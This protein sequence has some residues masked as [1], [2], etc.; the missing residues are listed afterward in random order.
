MTADD[1][2]I[3]PVRLE[4]AQALWRKSSGMRQFLLDTNILGAYL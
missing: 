3:R 2:L 4:D 1:V